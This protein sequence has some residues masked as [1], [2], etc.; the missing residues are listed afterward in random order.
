MPE[1]LYPVQVVGVGY[2]CD[3]CKIGMMQST[4]LMLTCYP[5]MY[6]HKCDQC[7]TH[8]D[9]RETYPCTRFELI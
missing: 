6:R 2:V 8:V 3:E 7:G 1:K 5:P 9:L 4:G